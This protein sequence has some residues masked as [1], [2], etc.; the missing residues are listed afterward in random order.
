MWVMQSIALHCKAP[1]SNF[2]QRWRVQEAFEEGVKASPRCSI[3][4]SLRLARV[5]EHKRV[6]K[7]KRVQKSSRSATNITC[8]KI[9]KP[10][11][12]SP[13]LHLRA[14][15]LATIAVN[16]RI[17]KIMTHVWGVLRCTGKCI[18]L[19][20]VDRTVCQLARRTRIA[21]AVNL[22]CC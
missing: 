20:I 8:N 16:D 3:C 21:C 12:C 13:T 6:Q 19:W 15:N 4:F 22:Q 1:Q 2:V 17:L 9:Y 18:W 10:L 14:L 11:R 5:Q 7:C